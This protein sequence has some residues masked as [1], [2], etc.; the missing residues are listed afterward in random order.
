MF[1]GLHDLLDRGLALADGLQ[2]ALRAVELLEHLVDVDRDPDGARLVGDRAG[3]G[4]ADPP[5]GVGREL[6]AL[7]VVELL[8]RAHQA[9]RALLDQVHERQ[10]L[11]AVALGDRDHEAEVGVHH[12]V[13]G[14]EVA[15]LDALGELELLGGGEQPRLG[16]AV[17][18]EL[19]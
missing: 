17:E 9:D 14:L 16:D 12:P 7:A 15:A 1:G 19:E 4:L 13:L 5:G 6:E 3:D 18:E 11:V 8:D 2:P 10:A